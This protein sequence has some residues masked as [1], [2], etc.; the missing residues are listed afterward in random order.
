MFD[1]ID[2][3][4]FSC[5]NI[6]RTHI[7]RKPLSANPKEKAEQFRFWGERVEAGDTTFVMPLARAVRAG[8]ITAPKAGTTQKRIRE[9]LRRR[10]YDAYQKAIEYQKFGN[11]MN[12][13]GVLCMLGLEMAESANWGKLLHVAPSDFGTSF[14]KLYELAEHFG[15]SDRLPFVAMAS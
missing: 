6:H 3:I 13:R 11:R 12:G 2:S 8:E 9:V 4:W 5:T 14:E 10:F 7:G 1:N 15:V